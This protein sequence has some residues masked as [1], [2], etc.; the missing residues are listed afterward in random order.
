MQ[1]ILGQSKATAILQSALASDRTHHAWIFHGN[2]GVG[3]FTTANA[4]ARILLCHDPQTDL[5]GQREACGGC[6]SCKRIDHP[7]AVHPD[8]HIVQKELAAQSSV[9]TVRSRKL[10][11]IPVDLLREYVIGGETSDGKFHDAAASK[12]PALRHGKVFIIDE[13]HLLA[14]VGQNTLLK[15]LEEPPPNTYFILVTHQLDQLLI[16]IRSRCQAVSFASLP[17]EVINQWLANNE[18]NLTERETQWFIHFC[19]GS[20]GLAEM[21]RKFEL[22]Q[23]ARDLLPGVMELSRGKAAPMLGSDT[24]EKIDALAKTWV[25]SHKGASKEAA[26]KM[27]AHLMFHLLGQYARSRMQHIA[28]SAPVNDPITNEQQL[29]PWLCLI[30]SLTISQKALSSNVN[31]TLVMDHLFSHWQQAVNAQCYEPL[32]W[33]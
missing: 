1:G 7:E 13:A 33:Q 28:E 19:N 10:L 21:T 24:A 20:L 4:F 27:A 32:Q 11:S 16:T 31:L 8:L 15:T 22:V 6:E 14:P 25:D 12:S 26:N 17:D 23:W 2:E 30:D 18:L 29:G 3:K 5:A 9:A